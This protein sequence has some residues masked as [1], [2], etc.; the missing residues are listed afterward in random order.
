[1]REQ[2][3]LGGS[4]GHPKAPAKD[5]VE[6]RMMVRMGYQPMCRPSSAVPMSGQGMAAAQLEAGTL[7]HHQGRKSWPQWGYNG[8]QCHGQGGRGPVEVGKGHWEPLVTPVPWQSVRPIYWNKKSGNL[9]SQNKF[10]WEGG[11]SRR[12]ITTMIRLILIDQHT[13]TRKVAT[14]ISMH[15]FLLVFLVFC[16]VGWVLF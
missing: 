10:L 2:H 5:V 7:Q 13:G 9:H 1:M 16:L 8:V 15:V 12:H 11:V 6:A 4:W 14:H 3:S